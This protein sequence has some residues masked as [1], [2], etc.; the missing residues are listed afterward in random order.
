[1]VTQKVVDRSGEHKVGPSREREKSRS[2]SLLV[3][4]DVVANLAASEVRLVRCVRYTE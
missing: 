4:K 3:E 1:M 2:A